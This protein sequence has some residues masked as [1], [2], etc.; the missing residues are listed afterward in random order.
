MY[1]VLAEVGSVD[2]TVMA[3]ARWLEKKG[4]GDIQKENIPV[5]GFV[6]VGLNHGI[7]FPNLLVIRLLVFAR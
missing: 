6:A 5:A 1:I 3:R 4:R 7:E 2:D